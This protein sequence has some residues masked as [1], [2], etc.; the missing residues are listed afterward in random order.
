MCS[1]NSGKLFEET[2]KGQYINTDL[3]PN[4][5]PVQVSEPTE[6]SNQEGGGYTFNV[7]NVYGGL[8]EVRRYDE[9][10]TPPNELGLKMNTNE[11]L[12]NNIS[13][14]PQS[15][16]LQS[17]GKQTNYFDFIIDPDTNKKYNIYS[18]AGKRLLKDYIKLLKSNKK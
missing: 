13:E 17:G 6:S 14:Q 8:A 18:E 16:Q 10:H 11:E 5:E 15:V 3:N 2:G 7:D 4:V 9:T 12:L 1:L